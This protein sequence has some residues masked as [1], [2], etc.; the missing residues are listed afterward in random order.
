[1]SDLEVEALAVALYTAGCGWP[2]EKWTTGETGD[3]ARAFYR[4]LARAA[5]AHIAAQAN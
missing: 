2:P 1:M 5:L 3:T 4:T